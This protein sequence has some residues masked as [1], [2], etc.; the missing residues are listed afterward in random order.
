MRR[1]LSFVAVVAWVM[2]AAAQTRTRDCGPDVPRDAEGYCV[3]PIKPPKEKPSGGQSSVAKKKAGKEAPKTFDQLADLCEKNNLA[4][5]NEAGEYLN[6]GNG[7]KQDYFNAS[8]YY[9]R[10]CMGGVGTSCNNLG[11]LHYGG[12][13]F[14]QDK[15]EALKWYERACGFNDPY[16]CN[17]A[18]DIY[19]N[20]TDGVTADIPKGVPLLEKACDKGLH[21][22]C[23]TLADAYRN[24]THGFP[25]DLTR[26]YQLYTK[27]GE[28]PAALNGLGLMYDAGEGRTA[29]QP[30][31]FGLF[32]K[33]CEAGNADGCAYVA[34]CYQE[35]RGTGVD[36]EKGDQFMNKACEMNQATACRMLGEKAE[37]KSGGTGFN[38]SATRAFSYYLKA[39]NGNDGKG[40][41][42]VGR[43]YAEGRGTDKDDK[44]SLDAYETGCDAG[45]PI[46]CNTAGEMLEAGVGVGAPD[47]EKAARAY[48]FA[49]GGK[50]AH[51]CLILGNMYVDGRGVKADRTMAQKLYAMGCDGKDE[52]ACKKAKEPVPPPA[53]G[54]WKA[55]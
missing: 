35:G 36:L 4:A 53:P 33:S 10:A 21:L 34:V 26:A 43:M 20:G 8:R 23:V 31:A 46:A 9:E 30:K 39:C 37:S 24:E 12:K 27:A 50:I 51:A 19:F 38:L 15:A 42:A 14:K 18:G 49:C 52:E 11:V 7:V 44:A 22:S 25:H 17:N 41:L 5:C 2:P 54:G 48:D 28:E 3:M 45:E 47:L 32:N 1:V 6:V 16:G 13:Y 55:Q 40:C 29:N